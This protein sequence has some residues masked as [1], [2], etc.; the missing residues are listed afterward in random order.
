MKIGAKHLI[1]S[2]FGIFFA[3]NSYAACNDTPGTSCM[4]EVS[5]TIVKGCVITQSSQDID[6]GTLD[7]GLYHQSDSGM[8][9][10]NLVQDTIV[11]MRCTPGVALEMSIDGG[12]HYQ[13][14]H[15][16]KHSGADE[17]IR[18]QLYR[19]SARQQSIS[20][21]TPMRIQLGSDGRLTL[22]L[23]GTAD[24]T[25]GMRAGVYQDTITVV[26]TY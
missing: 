20:I 2:L 21:N 10:A 26:I 23:F 13:E 14:T 15:R 7:F 5:A 6:F 12:K 3:T 17:Y 8:K 9:A 18:Y 11:E 1:I 24:L 22:P 4:I 16:L 19:D 25:S